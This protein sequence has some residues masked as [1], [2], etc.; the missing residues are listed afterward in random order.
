MENLAENAPIKVKV[1][2][3]VIDRAKVA[4]FGKTMSTEDAHKPC[5]FCKNRARDPPLRDNYIGKQ[6]KNFLKIKPK[7][8]IKHETTATVIIICIVSLIAHATYNEI[9][10]MSYRNSKQYDILHNSSLLI[11]LFFK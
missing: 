1:Y 11:T 8:Y 6:L 10:Q 3:F 2:N 9:I 5:K 7:H 4:K